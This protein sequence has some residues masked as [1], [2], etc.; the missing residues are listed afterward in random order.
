[1]FVKIFCSLLLF[2]IGMTAVYFCA[3][4]NTLECTRDSLSEVHRSGLISAN[5]IRTGIKYRHKE[6]IAAG[7]LVRAELDPLYDR[8]GLT[9]YRIRLVLSSYS[10]FLTRIY[11]VS[12]GSTID[13]VD[14]INY[15]IET[16]ALRSVSIVQDDRFIGASIG[17]VFLIAG[18]IVLI[19]L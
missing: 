3:R 15:F 10:T 5:I 9:V 1:V 18:I 7:E 12:Y 6:Y 17:V 19:N 4:R 8:K 2:A 13:K 11:S 16:G 14:R